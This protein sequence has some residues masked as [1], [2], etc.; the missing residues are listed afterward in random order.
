[1]N[2]AMEAMPRYMN[3]A[4]GVDK[5]WAE[6]AMCRRSETSDISVAWRIS[7]GEE[8]R[9]GESVYKASELIALALQICERCPVQWDCARF[10]I[11]VGEDACTWGM[12]L[13]DLRKLRE[14][15]NG[16]ALIEKARAEETPVQQIVR[17]VKRKHDRLSA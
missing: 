9:I 16:L 5:T 7:E 11:I 4:M 3:A 10:A 6:Q 15:D 12:R 2:G 1:M 17:R 13:Q 8:F 14:W